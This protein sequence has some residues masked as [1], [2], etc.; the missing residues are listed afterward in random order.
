MPF[1]NPSRS[2]AAIATA[3]ITCFVAA[4]GNDDGPPPAPV[5]AA[6]TREALTATCNG[7]RGQ[8]FAGVT[9]TATRRVEADGAAVPAG[10][11]QVSATRAP[12]LD[13]EVDVPDN[14]SGRLLHQGGGGFDG[15]IPTAVTTSS[16]GVVTALN[17]AIG[18][19]AAIYAASNGGN[20]ANVPA[21]AAPT[22]WANGT[23]DGMASA[24]D[25]AYR[26]LGT[27][28]AFAK[29][30]ARQFY[31]KAPERTYFNGCSNGGRNAYT[32]VQRWPDEYDGVVSGCETMDMGGQ[33]TA[34]L[35]L[36]SKAGTPAALTAPQYAAAFQAAVR[37]CDGNDGVVDG[38]IAN[39]AAC[40][41]DPA[42]LQCGVAGANADPALC[43]SAAQVGTLRSL[44]G[45]VVLANGA[46]VYSRFTWAD[47]SAFGP[48]FGSL[49]GGFALLATNDPAWLTLPKQ[50]SFN[51]NTDYY[52]FSSGLLRR[53]AD[54]DKAEIA[55]W[56]ASGKKLINWHDGA[57]NLLSLN[58]HLRN[59]AT[60]TGL[61]TNLGLA[62]PRT[63]SRFFVVPGGSHGEGQSFTEVDWFGAIV[64]WVENGVAPVQLVYTRPSGAT[65]RT[66]PVCEWPAWPR[67]NGS[68]DVAVS[69]NY[70]CTRT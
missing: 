53:G 37:S 1:P 35:N 46:T 62:D 43:L 58:D 10:L 40:T 36:G 5:A 4:C 42:A 55:R 30:M 45:D 60:M 47:F 29:T 18:R 67:Y 34:W 3:C 20:R 9:V 26:A 64:D 41:F 31:A 7:L 57:D 52:V 21:Q 59:Y 6:P 2:A 24:D 25:Y 12:F 51:L 19:K 17:T 39:P 28:I 66:L 15:T 49:G 44:L 69:T 32:V 38:I 11:C 50:Q 23:S 16:A 13:I 70:S 54:H 56:I 14:W 63:T 8:V 27:T 22:V 61:A 48:A 65:S 68:G 33:T